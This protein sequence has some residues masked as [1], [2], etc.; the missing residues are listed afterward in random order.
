M[1]K[2]KSIFTDPVEVHRHFNP[3]SDNFIHGTGGHHVNDD[4]VA[5]SKHNLQRKGLRYDD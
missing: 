2:T 5:L 4:S 3:D 1:K